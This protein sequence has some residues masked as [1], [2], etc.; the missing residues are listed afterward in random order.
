MPA[1]LNTKGAILETA[2]DLFSKEGYAGT[3]IRHIASSVGIRESAIYNHFKSK[4]DILKA[5]VDQFKSGT[6]GSDI[7]NEELIDELD[8]PLRFIRDF[9]LRLLEKWNDDMERKFFRLL[10]M[11]QFR[12]IKG[13]RLSVR[14]YFEE[15]RSIWQM[16]F[17]LMGKH[18]F[19]KKIDSKIVADEFVAPLYF[20]RME[21]LVNERSS[22][23]KNAVDKLNKHLEFFWNAIKTTD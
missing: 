6:A 3:S 11:E 5:I 22:D 7:I 2:L 9:S 21:Y 8:N 20:I 15:T 18:K 10:L 17:D 19:I 14:D 16:I 23:F 1:K 12:E 13:I 4:E